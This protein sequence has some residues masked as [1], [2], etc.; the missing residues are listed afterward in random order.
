MSETAT[1]PT[2]GVIAVDGTP[3]KRK[4]ARALFRS[5]VRA[6]GLVVPLLLMIILAFLV[7]IIVFLTQAV[8]NNSF[9][10]YMPSVSPMLAA[11]DAESEPTEEMFA[12]LAADLVITKNNKNI[13]KV[14][15]RVNRELSGTRSLFTKSARKAK[16]LEAP[17]KEALIDVDKKW[18]NIATWQAMKISEKSLTP[19]YL[20]NAV[21]LNYE[22]DGSYTVKDEDRRIHIKLF[23]RTL[24]ISIFVTLAGVILGYPVAFLLSTLPVRTS[25]LLLILVLLPFWTSLLVR[26]TAWIAVL[27][28]QGVLND[29]FVVFG[30]AADDDRFS[31][32][33]NKTGTLISMTHILLPFMILPL[34]SVMKTIPVSYVRA[35]KSMGATNWT[36]FWRVYFPQT[37]PGIGAGGILVFILAI[38]FYI[39]PALVGGQNGTMIS[40]FIDFHMRSSL[41]WSLAAAMG[42]VLLVIVLFFYWLYDRIVGIDNMKLG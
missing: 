4:L 39:T 16:K 40:N 14:A 42:M 19:A 36:A 2:D 24:Q 7:P 27:Q 3:L 30:L 1:N 41:N 22:A 17:F 29:L 23:L 8:Y 5:R 12:A 13:G 10:R 18:A 35:A 21:D 28:G 20:A 26:T 34:Y 38:S 6:F 32:I 11:W 33:Y 15:T 31:L 9:E 25:N 37:I